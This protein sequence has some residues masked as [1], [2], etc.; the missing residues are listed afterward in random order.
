MSEITTG[1]DA[2]PITEVLTETPIEGAITEAKSAS[3]KER[4]KYTID[5]EDVEEE[6]DF[7]DKEGLKKRFQMG[8]AAQKRMAEA[9]AAK[10]KAYEIVK[11]F[12]E[13][14]ANVFRRLG[15]KGRE[16]AEKF[17]LE[18]IQD[19]MMS[20]EEKDYRTTK[21]KLAKYEA[22]EAKA[23]EE[24]E[25]SE[26]SAK[27]NK[28]A[29]DFQATIISALDKSGLPKTPEL[30]KRMAGIMSKNLELGLDLTP[31][32]LASE[33]KS[34]F[35]QIF[36]SMMGDSDGDQIIKFLGDEMSNKIRKSDIRKLQE[37]Q[38]K[39]FQPKQGQGFA[40]KRSEPGVSISMDEWK[41]SWGK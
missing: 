39:V 17:L 19:D 26:V 33:V 38:N 25:K 3:A 36:K 11:A 1:G 41:E 13:D 21:S 10:S 2:A 8:H 9:K 28:Y 32:E 40:A 5:G 18:Q 35:M 12:E 14:P 6:I 4:F 27:E 24:A 34:D 16:A 23:K 22:Q 29:Q 7:S 20:P 31:D 37:N 30:V 15:P